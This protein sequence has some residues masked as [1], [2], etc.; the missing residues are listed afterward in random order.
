L[1]PHLVQH[2]GHAAPHKLPRRLG[3]REA[4]ANDMNRPQ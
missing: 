3:A 4:A 1:R 2:D